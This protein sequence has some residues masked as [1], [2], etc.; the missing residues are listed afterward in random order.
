MRLLRVFFP[1]GLQ[2]EFVEQTKLRSGLSWR[3]YRKR[4]GIVNHV[5]YRYEDCSMPSLV[6]RKALKIAKL[7]Y[8]TA[9]EY[10]YR[11]VREPKETILKLERT[12]DLAELIGVCLGDGHLSR[13]YFA[14]FGDK[15]KDTTYLLHHVKPLIH[16]NTLGLASKFKTNRPH[17]N[18]LVV[19][20][21]ACTRALSRQGL[22]YGD[23]IMN[24]ARI[25]LWIFRKTSFMIACLRGLFD[26]DGCVYGFKRQP[27]ARGSKAIISFE[28]GR[29]SHIPEDVYKALLKLRYTPRMM[30]AKN[31]CRLTMNRDIERFMKHIKPA[32]NKHHNN[33]ARWH[34]PV[35]QPGMDAYKK[36]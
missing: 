22:P 5:H 1:E 16:N 26:T 11:Y 35:V 36:P 25:P 10:R 7:S 32:N 28:F 34:G 2:Q 9:K 29:G 33:Y 30:T 6:F 23:K 27:P 24:H 4:L 20:S 15:T 8:T 13:Y 14:V 31:E 21:A 17:E 12:N 18:Y 19:N 3:Q